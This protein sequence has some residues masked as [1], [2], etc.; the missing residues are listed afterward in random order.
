MDRSVVSV[1]KDF[2]KNIG[3]RS[4]SFFLYVI[5]SC[6]FAFPLFTYLSLAMFH[7]SLDDLTVNFFLLLGKTFFMT[8]LQASGSAFL[9]CFL[10]A[11]LG[12][13][14]FLLPW[15][16]MPRRMKFFEVTSV[17]LYSLPGTA[18]AIFILFLYQQVLG[19]VAIGL[20]AI[21]AAHV[22]LNFSIVAFG[23]FTRLSS[24]EMGPGRDQL[25]A[26]LCLGASK[27]RTLFTFLK[28]PLIDELK[29][30]FLLIGLFSFMSFS[31]VLILGGGP[32]FSTPE[33]LLFYSLNMESSASRLLLTGIF[34]LAV[35]AGVFFLLVKNGLTGGAAHFL[36]VSLKTGPLSSGLRPGKNS[37]I[38]V[39]F[40][41]SFVPALLFFVWPTFEV[42]KSVF[43][44]RGTSSVFSYTELMVASAHSFLFA[45]FS[46]FFSWCLFHLCL[47]AHSSCRKFLSWG[48][49]LSSTFVLV[50]WSH[51]FINPDFLSVDILRLGFV[52]LMFSF[53][54]LP[55]I[56]FWVESRF[57]ALSVESV[58]CAIVLGC[59]YK[60]LSRQLLRPF[61]MD[62]E[63]RIPFVLVFMSLGEIAL[64]SFFISD[65][66]L[67]PLLSRQMAARYDFRGSVWILMSLALAAALLFGLWY[68]WDT[69]MGRQRWAYQGRMRDPGKGIGK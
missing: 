61:M 39:V 21:L 55:M 42:I 60:S 15:Q 63:R 48:V 57:Q 18:A 17:L 1:G 23:V 49:T 69:W 8:L 52:A 22:F 44:I 29:K 68:L 59:N 34:Q 31:I 25:E 33:V 45:S 50:A 28:P 37:W 30:W 36:P 66:P 58:E 54:F 56:C 19:R 24:W 62:I 20:E 41:G 38:H 2:K 64:S 46:A 4:A 65:L 9:S 32:D 47:R 35:S 40:L 6:V 67:L 26:S 27:M 11:F 7:F 43:W 12:V 13:M 16:K 51:T 5:A 53:A 10:G 14:I 3:S